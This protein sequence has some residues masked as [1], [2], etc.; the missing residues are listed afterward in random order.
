MSEM[1]CLMVRDL[2]A[3]PPKNSRKVLVQITTEDGSMNMAADTKRMLM[4]TRERL[5]SATENCREDMHASSVRATVEGRLFD[6]AGTPNELAIT[7][8]N[9]NDDGTEVVETF[10]LATLVALALQ[11]KFV[12]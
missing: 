10:K 12:E 5:R 11:A 4:E 1:M 6:N 8:R 2:V 9:L 7:L 3:N